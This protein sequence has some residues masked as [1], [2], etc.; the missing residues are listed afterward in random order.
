MSAPRFGLLTLVGLVVAN[1]IGAGVFTTSGLA[2]AD[3]G[4][5]DRVMLAW[6]TGGL[7]AVCGALSYGALVR[8]MTESGGEYLFLS[9]A[10]HPAAGF[11]A[12]WVSL[13][14]GFTGAIALAA[15]ALEAYLLPAGTRPVWI[16]EDAVALT[17]VFAAGALHVRKVGVGA[18][19]QNALV[20]VKLI[21]IG[22]ITVYAWSKLSTGAVPTGTSLAIGD[23]A[24]SDF[25]WSAFA[26]SLMWISLSYSGFNAAVY[27]AGEARDAKRQVPRALILGTVVVTVVYLALNALFVYG[28]PSTAI[29]G[30]EDVAARA[31][32]AL[33]GEPLGAAMR[34]IVI[35]ALATSVSS[36]IMAGPRVYARMADDG[37]LPRMFATRDGRVAR[38]VTLQVVLAALIIVVSDLRELLS[39]LGFT[40]SVSAALTVS[41]LFVL[42]RREGAVAVPVPGYPWVPGLYVGATLMFAAIA[43]LHR[44]LEP[45]V[46]VATLATGVVAWLIIERRARFKAP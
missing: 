10:I 7:L 31:L 23:G 30:H 4:T 15:T 13:L 9:R 18:G 5:P 38:A 43:A 14:A 37:V 11:V 41:S 20:I 42:R 33:G 24:V 34:G 2:L 35:L 16:P 44:P 39:Y 40:L 1:M 8:R 27:I 29:A 26:V 3:L 28:A 32:T 6:L 46:G 36:M 12:G 19:V 45:V 17:V 21:M 22:A 25:E